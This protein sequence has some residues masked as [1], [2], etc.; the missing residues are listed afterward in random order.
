MHDGLCQMLIYN[1][2]KVHADAK[3]EAQEGE[4]EYLLDLRV[5]F[6]LGFELW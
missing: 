6:H 4:S 5:L 3:T 1:L 2:E